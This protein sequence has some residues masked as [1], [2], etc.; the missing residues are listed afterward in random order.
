MVDGD[1]AATHNVLNAEFGELLRELPV[2]AQ[3]DRGVL[4][5]A[6]RRVTRHIATLVHSHHSG[7]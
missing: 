4:M 6:D 5:Q 3:F 1:A 7:L 2:A